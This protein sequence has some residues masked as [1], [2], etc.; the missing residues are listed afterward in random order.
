MASKAAATARR[1][2][3]EA[4]DRAALAAKVADATAQ[5]ARAEFDI[6]LRTLSLN[7]L[8][9]EGWMGR[10]SRRQRERRTTRE[11]TARAIKLQGATFPPLPCIITIDRHGPLFVDDDGLPACTKII[12]DELALALGAPDDS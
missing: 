11:A 9:G 6:H 7:R 4:D 5:W 3:R 12:R 2:M 10:K 8:G 1:R